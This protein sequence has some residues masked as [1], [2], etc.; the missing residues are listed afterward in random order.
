MLGGGS[1]VEAQGRTEREKVVGLEGL[2]IRATF[3][4][5]SDGADDFAEER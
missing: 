1:A 2:D 3:F 4:T 5:G